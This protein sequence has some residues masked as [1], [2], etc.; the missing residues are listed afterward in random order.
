VLGFVEQSRILLS[1]YSLLP[2]LSM[3][4]KLTQ[5]GQLYGRILVIVLLFKII[6]PVSRLKGPI[7]P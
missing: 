6:F 1:G 2:A 3:F 4:R 5:V 7:C